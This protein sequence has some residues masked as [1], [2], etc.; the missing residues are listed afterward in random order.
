MT[1]SNRSLA[2]ALSA[3]GGFLVPAIVMIA[4]DPQTL[5]GF[6]KWLF[7]GGSL[8]CAIGVTVT[9]VAWLIVGEPGTRRRNAGLI[10][11][12]S[13][14]GLGFGVTAVIVFTPWSLGTADI[15]IMALIAAVPG[16]TLLGFLIGHV[17]SRGAPPMQRRLPSY[18]P[19]PRYHP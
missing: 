3:V 14:L 8:V 6:A 13:G 15:K 11:V 1:S 17:V 5:G 18:T 4:I 12:L 19:G 2:I 9:I 7:G 16:C 10:G